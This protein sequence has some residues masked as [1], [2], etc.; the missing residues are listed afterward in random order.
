VFSGIDM[1]PGADTVYLAL[2]DRQAAGL[3]ELA[4]AAGRPE[5]ETEALLVWL[6]EH[7]LVL[8]SGGRWAA[9]DPSQALRSLVRAREDEL[10]RLHGALPGFQERFQRSRSNG[11]GS[12]AGGGDGGAPLLEQLC[13]WEENGNRHHELL[14]GARTEIMLWDHAPYTAGPPVPD[15]GVKLRILADPGG[16][17]PEVAGRFARARGVQARLHPG[18]PFRG[19]IADRRLAVVMLDRETPNNRALLVRPSPLLDALVL[20]YEISWSRAVPVDG[21][22]PGLTELEHEVLTLLAAGLK[23]EAIARQLEVTTRT[24]RRRVQAVL[25][26]LNA[27]SRFE[28]GAEAARRGLV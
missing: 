11:H 4:V 21:A 2:L 14:R 25:T 1:P 15:R 8:R 28:A 23:D 22:P 10:L 26:A 24:V 13:G 6:R 18:L 3:S 19:A 9:S 27:R 16:M 20:L 5:P 7:R 12:A 17:G